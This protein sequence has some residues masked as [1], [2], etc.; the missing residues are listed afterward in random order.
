MQT[1][2][3][4]NHYF[5]ILSSTDLFRN[6]DKYSKRWSILSIIV[7]AFVLKS[8]YQMWYQN[9]FSYFTF[10]LCWEF[11]FQALIPCTLVVYLNL[12]L[13]KRLKILVASEEYNLQANQALRRSILRARL[14]LSITFIFVSSQLLTWI[15]FPIEVIFT[16][17]LRFLL[18]K[19]Y[20]SD[21]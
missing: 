7:L 16:T 21:H 19:L 5:W 10:A 8:P 11:L 6:T 2:V 12:A 20:F 15:P 9:N 3:S 14:S 1:S 17:L 18:S 4:C 13:Y